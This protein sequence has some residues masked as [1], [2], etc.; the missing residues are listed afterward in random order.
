MG[1][2]SE[3]K[4]GGRD[5]SDMSPFE[6][7]MRFPELAMHGI[8]AVSGA[9]KAD[10]VCIFGID[11]ASVAGDVLS[12]MSDEISDVPVPMVC[13]G[14]V[15]G[16][17]G[18]GTLGIIISYEGNCPQMLDVYEE[19]RRRG[20]GIVCLTSGGELASRCGNDGALNVDIPSRMTSQSATGFV[21]GALASIVQGSGAFDAA[22]AL[23]HD[24]RALE[25]N[26]DECV[27]SAESLARALKGRIVAVYSTSDTRACSRRWKMS[28]AGQASCL[29]F[30]GELPEFDHNEL[31]G[32]SDPNDHAPGLAMVVLRG[33]GKPGLVPVIV[34]CMMEV[35][36]ENGRDVVEVD[37]GSGSSVSRNIRGIMIGDALAYL[38]GG[39]GL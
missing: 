34:E 28:L 13:D 23:L 37:L 14:R 1:C 21:L 7:A 39:T 12:D 35:L 38:M 17:V 24:L 20:A 3:V 4:V 27:R 15:P 2:E 5:V 9:P 33:S 30:S 16:W 29:A 25:G 32:W 19:L 31:V 11:Q 26:R 6:Q 8:G 18:P 36:G 22:D 10:S